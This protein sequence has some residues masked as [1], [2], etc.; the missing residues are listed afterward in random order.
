MKTYV[1]DEAQLMQALDLINPVVIEAFANY[2]NQVLDFPE[3]SLVYTSPMFEV[4]ILEFEPGDE[5]GLHD[6]PDMTG[7]ILCVGGS[8]EIDN[9]DEV[10]LA[11]EDGDLFV[12]RI[13]KVTLSPGDVATLTAIRGNIHSLRAEEFIQLLD[14]FTP[15]Y[16]DGRSD[17]SRWFEREAKP[18]H[19]S[20]GLTFRA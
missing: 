20:G 18:V 17:R 8:M 19:G 10:D 6:H 16:N 9:F 4:V 11:N 14:V 3:I 2:A 7:V 1:R 5:I 13:S 15:P 12:R